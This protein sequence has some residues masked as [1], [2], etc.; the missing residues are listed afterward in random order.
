[1]SARTVI[2]KFTGEC[3]DS[4]LTTFND[5][6]E[7]FPP[8]HSR[9]ERKPDGVFEFTLN[10]PADGERCEPGKRLKTN[11]A[12]AVLVAQKLMEKFEEF[13]SKRHQTFHVLAPDGKFG[14]VIKAEKK[15][16]CLEVTIF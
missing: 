16:Y 12:D 13:A 9:F 11:D 1:M 10:M 6:A 15:K 5:V 2:F 3:L 8:S 4:L 7:Q 14:N